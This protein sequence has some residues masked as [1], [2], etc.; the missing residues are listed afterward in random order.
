MKK[1]LI[2]AAGGALLVAAGVA[3]DSKASVIKDKIVKDECGACHMAY[4]PEFLPTASWK[5]IMNGLTD[6]FGGDASLDEMTIKHITDYLVKH[7]GRNRRFP[8]GNPPLRI[9]KLH[10]FVRNHSGEV[11]P[12]SRKRAGTMSNCIACH[13]DAEKGYFGDD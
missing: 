8:K 3:Q 11:S 12:R 7:A 10:W 13:R 1:S 9:T 2:F 4:Q 5:V 6:H